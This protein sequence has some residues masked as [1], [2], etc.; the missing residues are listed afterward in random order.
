MNDGRPEAPR[1]PNQGFFLCNEL[2]SLLTTET[3]T[4]SVLDL[5]PSHIFCECSVMSLE[6]GY[7]QATASLGVCLQDFDERFCRLREHLENF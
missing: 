7:L 3:T 2:E 4:P 6:A 1:R 5:T